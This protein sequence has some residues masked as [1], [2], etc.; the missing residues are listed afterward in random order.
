MC[1]IHDHLKWQMNCFNLMSL[2][3]YA[4]NLFS[5][6]AFHFD[7]IHKLVLVKWF[8][9]A[10]KHSAA[11]IVTLLFIRSYQ[12]MKICPWMKNSL[13][14]KPHWPIY[15]IFSFLFQFC[16]IHIGDTMFF[17]VARTLNILITIIVLFIVVL[18]TRHIIP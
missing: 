8:Y 18:A 12:P 3:A 17:V 9:L 14:E 1:T 16:I 5:L 7:V 11:W 15:K 4:P 13:Y 10:D 2:T 6:H